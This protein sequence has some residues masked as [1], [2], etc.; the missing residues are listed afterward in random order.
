MPRVRVDILLRGGWTRLMLLAF[1]NLFI[2]L[3]V[4]SL[5]LYHIGRPL[6]MSILDSIKAGATSIWSGI[7]HFFK[8]RMTLRY[9]DQKLDLEGPGL[10]LRREA[11]GG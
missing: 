1:V 6:S 5:G 4:L 9:P 2:A 11:G 10:Q 7:R 8:P 3:L